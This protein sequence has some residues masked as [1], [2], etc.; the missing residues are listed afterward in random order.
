[1]KTRAQRRRIISR[2]YLLW[3]IIVLA[4]LIGLG[5]WT[6][7]KT[8]T[9]LNQTINYHAT[10]DPALAVLI[11][12]DSLNLSVSEDMEN[13]VRRPLWSMLR[14]PYIGDDMPDDMPPPPEMLPD[15]L[16]LTEQ[17]TSVIIAGDTQM[18]FLKGE[19]GVIRLELGM[20]Y[21]GWELTNVNEDSAEFHSG[22]AEKVLQLRTFAT[23]ASV[24]VRTLGGGQGA[25][26]RPDNTN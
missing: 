6:F 1:M 18:I 23:E 11:D 12:D 17:L 22:E 13:S 15:M 14:R 8:R 3:I 19:Q 16:P 25:V 7:M 9:A 10:P 2:W 4:L 26:M 24:P 21:K 5:A 20:I